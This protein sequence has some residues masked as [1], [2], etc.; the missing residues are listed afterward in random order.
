MA[1]VKSAV[2]AQAT[3]PI[4]KEDLVAY[5]ASGCKP[6]TKWRQVLSLNAK[7]ALKHACICHLHVTRP[8][9]LV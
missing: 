9:D 6:R 5:I 1:H 7:R 3:E 8:G 2:T 4:T